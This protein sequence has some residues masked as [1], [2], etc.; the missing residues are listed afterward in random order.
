L[1][2]AVDWN[3]CVREHGLRCLAPLV[4]CMRCDTTHDAALPTSRVIM[5]VIDA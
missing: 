1:N 3:G 4:A 5:G 2:T